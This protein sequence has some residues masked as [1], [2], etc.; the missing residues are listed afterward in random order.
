[1]LR[2]SLINDFFLKDSSFEKKPHWSGMWFAVPV[3]VYSVFVSTNETFPALFS[4]IILRLLKTGAK[5]VPELNRITGL[6]QDLL[7]YIL[8]NE[9]HEKVRF[10]GD[11]IQISDEA[12]LG[13]MK[14]NNAPLREFQIFKVISIGTFVP[15]P[16]TKSEDVW[17]EPA[18]RDKMNFPIFSFRKS[19]GSPEQ[20]IAPIVLPEM[21]IGSVSQETTDLD[22]IISSWKTYLNDYDASINYHGEYETRKSSGKR[23]PYVRKI[24]SINIE[25]KA[26][27]LTTIISDEED[28]D[29]WSCSDPF[30]VYQERGLSVL[31]EAV[32]LFRKNETPIAKAITQKI[33]DITHD[34]K[35]SVGY[36]TSKNIDLTQFQSAEEK[37]FERY[38]NQ[39]PEVMQECLITLK[40]K[41]EAF[42]NGLVERH[43]ERTGDLLIQMQK[44]L[45]SLFKCT[46]K[47]GVIKN[48]N[49]SKTMPPIFGDRKRVLSVILANLGAVDKNHFVSKKLSYD[50]IWKYASSMKASLKS[51]LLQALYSANQYNNHPLREALKLNP[52]IPIDIITIADLRNEFGGHGSE[53]TNAPKPS[54][55]E[56]LELAEKTLLIAEIITK[57]W[58]K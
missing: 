42:A 7:L 35:R 4:S 43:K 1:M 44:T 56:I 5:T 47:R 46:W 41:E 22:E 6:D 16:F 45:E 24:Q 32:E 50:G 39:L 57:N 37:I 25:Q 3:D 11:H 12:T 34:T 15:R 33:Q 17:R 53:N 54:D 28:K 10:S 8:I 30:C 48:I 21:A 51:L 36:P 14:F 20:R 2:Q 40:I 23:R 49:L 18:G 38:G 31:K 27:V 52:S 9:L 19:K 29:G 13:K 58:E 55:K 26:Y